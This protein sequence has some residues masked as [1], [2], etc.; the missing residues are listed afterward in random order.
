MSMKSFDKFCEKMILG[1]P[2]SE[3]EIFDERQKQ[4]RTQILV[5]S[6]VIYA[7]ASALCVMLNE[8]IGFMESDFA[9]MAF[10]AGA[11]YLW[12]VISLAAKE[13]MFGVSGKQ[14]L[15]NALFAIALVP[16][17]ILM[18]L[19]NE[20]E[21]L[22][23]VKNGALTDRFVVLAALFLYIIATV[24]IIVTYFRNRRADR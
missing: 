8:I 2:G 11:V 23:I 19:S 18:M 10:C 3:K 21:L 14:V 22:A 17:Y 6:L 9:G 12:W 16:T 13:C 20:D 24:I 5:Q 4:L 15:Y 7:V 1:E